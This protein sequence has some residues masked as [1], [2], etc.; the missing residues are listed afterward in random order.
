M[1][2]P[3]ALFLWLLPLL[4]VAITSVKSRQRPCRR[5]LF[6]HAEPDR[7]SGNYIDVFQQLADR[8]NTSSIRSR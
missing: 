1:A 3:I 8:R 6:R 5:Q 7:L 4:G 2:L